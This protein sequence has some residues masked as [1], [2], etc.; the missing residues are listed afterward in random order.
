MRDAATPLTLGRFPTP[1]EHVHP[2]SVPDLGGAELWVKH[3]DRTHDVCG[4]NK[5]RKL[6]WLLADARARRSTRLLTIG[7]AGSHHVLATTYFGTR[8]GFDVHAV[9]V[10]QPRTDHV[11]EVLRAGIAMGLHVIPAR[12]WAAGAAAV[13]E[14][15]ATHGS[16]SERFITVGG[17]TVRGSMGYVRAARELATQVR[18]GEMPEPDLCVVA[19]GS[20]GTA[21]GLTA[22][23]AAEGMKTRVVGVC[24][25]Q[26]VW[27]LRAA[28]LY[29]SSACARQLASGEEANAKGTKRE[30]SREAIRA[31]L[32]MDTGFLG[33]GYGYET[34]DGADAMRVAAEVGLT[35]DPTYTAKA[36][37]AAL[38]LVRRGGR[39]RTVVLYWHTLSS[40]P[41]GPL[42]EHAPDVAELGSSVR[43]LLL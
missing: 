19:L 10:P 1:V 41:M 32:V 30:L 3:D 11:I 9:L 12:S 7:A 21:A 37:S 33:R 20:G 8:E 38:H 4:G 31:R 22:G 29:L 17:S 18:A 36:F 5:V 39:E 24:V 35:L 26:P 14:R 40:A 6:E 16:P 13:A 23:F 2:T 34:P 43:A 42:L 28:A 27:A 15:L 25:S